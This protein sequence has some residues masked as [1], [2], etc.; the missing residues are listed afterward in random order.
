MSTRILSLIL[1]AFLVFT[2]LAFASGGGGDEGIEVATCTNLSYPGTYNLTVDISNSATTCFTFNS[3]NTTLDCQGHIVDGQDLAGTYGVLNQGNNTVV[4]NC[5]FT[6]WFVGYYAF[7]QLYNNHNSTLQNITAYSQSAVLGGSADVIMVDASGAIMDRLNLSSLD[8]NTR[9]PLAIGNG[10]YNLL[11]NSIVGYGSF[12]GSGNLYV[13]SDTNYTITNLSMD[14]GQVYIPTS[15]NVDINITDTQNTNAVLLKAIDEISGTKLKFNYSVVNGASSFYDTSS[16][17]VVLTNAT[18]FTGA[19]QFTVN[20]TG[21]LQKITTITPAITT[22]YSRTFAM[23]VNTSTANNINVVVESMTYSPIAGATVE[24][25]PPANGYTVLADNKTS[26]SSGIVQFQGLTT[27]TS[28]KIVFRANGFATYTT[29]LYPTQTTYYVLLSPLASQGFAYPYNDIYCNWNQP[30]SSIANIT[31]LFT[32]QIGTSNNYALLDWCGWYVWN[33]TTLISTINATNT[34]GC[35]MSQSI[36]PYNVGNIT[37]QGFFKTTNYTWMNNCTRFWQ[38]YYFNTT[39]NNSVS[40]FITLLSNDGG[41]FGGYWISF[42]A[43]CIALEVGAFI[44]IYSPLGGLC[45]YVATLGVF[46]GIGMITPMF[47]LMNCIAAV[48]IGVWKYGV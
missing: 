34:T 33:G 19:P 23:A 45:G 13:Y 12:A 44:A 47:F 1:V 40:N 17:T 3:E 14:Y 18:N 15:K 22:N 25:Y 6:D 31:T 21:Y 16:R 27:T 26:D 48:A 28:Y 43:L 35:L 32:L 30:T 29:F 46:T 2:T 41:G 8:H 20:S 5:I 39:L 4:K 36:V 24:V 37:I 38:I 11:N 7:T 42:L 9:T 10:T